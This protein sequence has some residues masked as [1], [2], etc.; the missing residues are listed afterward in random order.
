VL[1]GALRA[2]R[3]CWTAAET[4]PSLVLGGTGRSGEGRTAPA[5]IV[6]I[7][8]WVGARLEKVNRGTGLAVLLVLA[9]E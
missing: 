7:A 8:V 3:A 5:L 2:D 6:G 9:A 4:A 1:A